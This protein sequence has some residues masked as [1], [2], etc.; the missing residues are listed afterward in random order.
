MNVILCSYGYTAPP[1]PFELDVIEK[2]YLINSVKN[3][4]EL[5]V[6]VHACIPHCERPRQ[7]DCKFK[8][9]LGNLDVW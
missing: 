6:V 9:S 5:G 1:R 3:I 2:M 4:F 8:P 7:E